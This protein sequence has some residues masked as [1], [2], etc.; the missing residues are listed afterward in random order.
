MLI[1]V[2]KMVAAGFSLRNQNK[3]NLKVAATTVML[4]QSKKVRISKTVE[5]KGGDKNESDYR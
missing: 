4:I 2:E 5:T 3:R 1:S